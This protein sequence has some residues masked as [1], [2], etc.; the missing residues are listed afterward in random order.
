MTYLTTLLVISNWVFSFYGFHKISETEELYQKSL[1]YHIS[2]S[3]DDTIYVFRDFEIK[4]PVRIKNRIIVDIR[5]FANFSD[6]KGEFS[7]VKILPIELYKGSVK[8][9]LVDFYVK[10]HNGDISLSNIG[11]EIFTYSFNSKQKK[12]QLI[13]RKKSI[14]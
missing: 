12:Y 11:C 6:Q 4:V 14:F 5:D 10:S 7:A 3:K 13:R 8:I 1:M 9:T 2:N